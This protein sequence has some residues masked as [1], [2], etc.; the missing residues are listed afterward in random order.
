VPLAYSRSFRRGVFSVSDINRWKDNQIQRGT[1]Y[2]TQL[3]D[4]SNAVVTSL[5]VD[6]SSVLRVYIFKAAAAAAAVAAV[7][8]DNKLVTKRR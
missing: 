5:V 4:C 7:A 2:I 3:V 8:N 6:A 1:S